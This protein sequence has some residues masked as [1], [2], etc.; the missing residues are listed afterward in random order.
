MQGKTPRVSYEVN[1]NEYDKPY[2]LVDGIYPDWATLVKTV[3]NPN[4]K[5]TKRFATMQEATRK[6][7]EQRFG[8]LQ[9]R[10]AIVRHPARTWSIQTM[11]EVMSCCVIMHNMIVED[12]RPDGKNENGWD[13]QGELVEPNPGPGT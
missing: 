8:V 4:T 5:K 9:A 6:D 13:F 2:Y 3:R 1:G 12:E 7:V 11:H 10:W